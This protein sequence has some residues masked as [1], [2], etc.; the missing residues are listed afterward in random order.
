GEPWLPLSTDRRLAKRKSYPGSIAGWSAERGAKPAALT[1]GHLITVP[2]A[3]IQRSAGKGPVSKNFTKRGRDVFGGI[4]F[5]NKPAVC[6]QIVRPV[7]PG[8]HNKVQRRPAVTD[9]V[10]EPEP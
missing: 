8:C 9:R 1:L 10:G 4:G 2:S 7:Q 6:R 3:A 5:A